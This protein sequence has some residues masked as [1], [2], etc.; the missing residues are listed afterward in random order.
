M[1]NLSV[2]I[3]LAIMPYTVY[4]DCI[5][6]DTSEKF[7]VVCSGPDPIFPAESKKNTKKTPRAGKGKKI[8]YEDRA[9]AMGEV[10]MNDVESQFMVT[11]NK[12][13]GYRP[14][15]KSREQTSKQT[16]AGQDRNI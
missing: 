1:K 9:E 10:V 3:L 12:Q 16:V 5:I 2:F 15:H 6:T 13:D 14:K 4:A 11:R 8:N 7:E